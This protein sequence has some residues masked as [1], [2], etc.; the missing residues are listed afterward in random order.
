MNEAA[1]I[2]FWTLLGLIAAQTALT[3]GFV[4]TLRA[5]PRPAPAVPYTPKAAV[6]LCLRGT[7][8]FLADCLDALLQQDYPDY[9]VRIVV[10]QPDDPAW[11][12]VR[13]ALPRAGT[14]PVHAAS[15]TDR[16]DT[17][18]LKCSSLT[19][20]VAGLDESFAV[21]AQLDADCVP[22]RTWLRELVAPLADPRCGAATGNRWYMPAEPSWGALVRSLWNAAAIVQ[23]YCYGIPW[24]G[25][26]A[27][28]MAVVRQ[29]DLLER[30][31]SAFCEDTLLYRV[32]RR[33]GLKVAFVPSLMMVNR[34]GCDVAGFVRWGCR[35]LL[36]AR[37]YHPAWPAVVGH[38]LA[39]TAATAVWLA[40]L[41]AAVGQQAWTA[42]AWLAAG[43]A[44]YWLAMPVLLAMIERAVQRTMRLRGEAVPR[45]SFRTAAWR[46]IAIPWTQVVYLVALVSALLVRRVDW[47]GVVYQV[48][49]PGRI[50]LIAYRPLAAAPAAGC[51]RQSL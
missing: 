16:R 9:A 38:G 12:V 23:M 30:W 28:K 8:P 20:A 4:R 51:S 7:D 46:L 50:R 45:P 14:V 32:L 15:L 10:D 37:L 21:I 6:V 18:S 25:T 19:Q 47:R 48:G 31:R 42:A 5:R 17:C 44:C 24:G 27:L 26:L 3:V 11:D 34:E 43:G 41:I 33:I 35:Q 13:A 22:H 2:G 1:M 49:G 40:L 39:T 29:A 36:T